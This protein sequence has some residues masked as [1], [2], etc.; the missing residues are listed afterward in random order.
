MRLTT[1]QRNDAC[2]IIPL[3]KW[4][5]RMNIFFLLITNVTSRKKVSVRPNKGEIVQMGIAS[6]RK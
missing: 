6:L 3:V 2:N 4:R 5:E 1:N